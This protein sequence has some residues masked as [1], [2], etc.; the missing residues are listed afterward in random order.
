MTMDDEAHFFYVV[1]HLDADG[2]LV[3]TGPFENHGIAE[4]WMI[5]H[6]EGWALADAIARMVV[7]PGERVRQ[8]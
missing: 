6:L 2:H 3:L 1:E 5:G 4:L 8:L 7:D